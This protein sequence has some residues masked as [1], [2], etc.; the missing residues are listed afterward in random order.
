MKT[1]QECFLNSSLINITRVKNSSLRKYPENTRH[2]LYFGN[3][4]RITHKGIHTK[5]AFILV[6][7]WSIVLAKEYQLKGKAKV[8]IEPIKLRT[9]DQEHVTTY[10]LP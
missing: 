8:I 10:Q 3:V 9:F 6:I 7:Q 5:T 1:V 4:E 2:V